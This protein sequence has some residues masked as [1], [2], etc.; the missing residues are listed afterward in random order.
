MSGPENPNQNRTKLPNVFLFANHVGL[1]FSSGGGFIQSF[2]K[3]NFN[4]RLP[5]NTKTLGLFV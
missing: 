5:W 2:G 1:I 4:N 3:P